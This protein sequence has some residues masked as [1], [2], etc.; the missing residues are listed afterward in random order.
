MKRE[1][2]FDRCPEAIGGHQTDG[3]GKCLWCGRKVGPVT[4]RPTSF[5]VS[6]LTDAYRT[7]YDPDYEP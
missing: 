2:E 4:P 3:S 5:E 1:Y 6:D 7:Y